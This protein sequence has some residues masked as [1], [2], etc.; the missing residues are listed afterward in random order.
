MK[1][2]MINFLGILLLSALTAPIVYS[3]QPLKTVPQTPQ[4]AGQLIEQFSFTLPDFKMD[5]QGETVVS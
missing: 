1:Q 3:Q 4:Q 2:L 5:H